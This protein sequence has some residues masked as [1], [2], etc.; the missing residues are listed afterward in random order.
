M[1]VQGRIN[2]AA[3][4]RLAPS[5]SVHCLQRPERIINPHRLECPRRIEAHLLCRLDYIVFAL[6]VAQVAHRLWRIGVPAE[7]DW[8]VERRLPSKTYNEG[9]ALLAHRLRS[10]W[11]VEVDVFPLAHRRAV[12]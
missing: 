3:V 2:Q 6:C 4:S 12:M 7:K 5:E 10:F 9:F 11:V 8:V 1:L